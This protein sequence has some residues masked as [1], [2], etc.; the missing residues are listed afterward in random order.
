MT[1]VRGMTMPVVQVVDVVIVGHGLVTAVRTVLVVGVGR[2]SCVG[3]LTF[4]P[5]VFVLPVHVSIVEIVDL[6]RVID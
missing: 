5:V 1:L 6:V 4:V 2:M 3:G